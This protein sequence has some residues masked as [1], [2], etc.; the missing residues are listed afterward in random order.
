MNSDKKVK[1]L[2]KKLQCEVNDWHIMVEAC[3]NQNAYS[4]SMLSNCINFC[5]QIEKIYEKKA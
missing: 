1:N 3:G 5:K 2:M 4:D